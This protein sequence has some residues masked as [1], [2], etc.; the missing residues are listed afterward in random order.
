MWTKTADITLRT[1]L[2][3]SIALYDIA[4]ASAA[5]LSVPEP[6]AAESKSKSP[7][8]IPELAPILAALDGIGGRQTV[9]HPGRDPGRD[10]P[11]GRDPSHTVDR[12][13]GE[14]EIR[15]NRLQTRKIIEDFA[16]IR[17]E[18]STYDEVYRIDCLRQGI[19]M[20]AASLP[21]NSEY[22]DAKRILRK[23]SNRLG[24][25]VATYQDRSMP[26]LVAPAGANP[27]FK[28]TRRY[29]AIRREA[30]PEAMA[31]A[32]DVVG[33]ATTALLRSSENSERRYAHYQ[34]ISVAVDSTKVLLRS[35]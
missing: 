21:D 16:S 5:L 4:P 1:A 10:T 24:R 18:C 29:T 35:S 9:D 11:G 12:D 23:T 3:I 14:R 7:M 6:A 17:G 22:R 32:Q 30:V 20:I 26:K 2:L 34:Q 13:R 19:D 28:K 27:R 31:K 33:E 15:L 25:I 8:D